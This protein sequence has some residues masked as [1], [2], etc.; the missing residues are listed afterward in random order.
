LAP[1]PAPHPR[2]V[3]GGCQ[4]EAGARGSRRLGRRDSSSASQ[5]GCLRAPSCPRAGGAGTASWAAYRYPGGASG[6]P[7]RSQALR[8]PA[9]RRRPPRRSFQAPPAHGGARRGAPPVCARAGQSP[10]WRRV[11]R[12]PPPGS[13]PC[14]TRHS[15]A[16]GWWEPWRRRRDHRHPRGAPPR[17]GD[18]TGDAPDARVARTPGESV[19]GGARCHA[20]ARA[21]PRKGKSR[22]GMTTCIR[23]LREGSAEPG[24]VRTRP[25]EGREGDARPTLAASVAKAAVVDHSRL[26]IDIVCDRGSLNRTSF[27]SEDCARTCHQQR[28]FCYIHVRV[29]AS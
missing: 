18:R 7:S 15:T 10:L 14:A 17:R 12:Q 16:G 13:A 22:G 19:T 1:L 27:R 8:P 4:Q 24:G 5:R 3:A 28:R 20:A 2:E 26:G 11:S 9:G 29:H 23:R 25:E 6:G 21:P